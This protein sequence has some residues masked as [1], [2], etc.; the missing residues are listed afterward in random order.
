MENPGMRKRVAFDGN[1]F[2]TATE[3]FFRH[4]AHSER[5]QLETR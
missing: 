2:G 1:D 5:S 4:F 3:P